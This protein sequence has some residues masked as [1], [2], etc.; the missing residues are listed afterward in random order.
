MGYAATTRWLNATPEEVFRLATDP[1]TWPAWL[2]LAAVRGEDR[3]L[4]DEVG[5]HA[6]GRILARRDRPPVEWHVTSRRRTTVHLEGRKGTGT[7]ARLHLSASPWHDGCQ[8]EVRYDSARTALDLPRLRR[9]LERGVAALAREFDTPNPAT[10]L[11]AWLDQREVARA[12]VAR[13]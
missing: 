6:P 1:A 8:F 13:T 11:Q 7:L 4:L 2:P 3:T 9:R 5:A 12:R 10:D